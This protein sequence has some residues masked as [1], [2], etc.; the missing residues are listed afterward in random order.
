MVSLFKILKRN[1]FLRAFAKILLAT[2]MVLGILLAALLPVE[3]RTSWLQAHLFSHWR[4][5]LNYSVEKGPSSRVVFPGRGPEDLRRGYAEL[6]AFTAILQ[7][8]G[9]VIEQQAQFSPALMRWTQRGFPPPYSEKLQ[10]GLRIYD[11][12]KTLLYAALDPQRVYPAFDSIPPLVVQTLLFIENQHLL[13]STRLWMNPAVDWPRFCKALGEVTKRKIGLPYSSMGGSTLATQ[14]EKYCHSGEGVTSTG[15]EKIDQM[16]SASMRA[17][18]DGP[19]T[20]EARRQIVLQYVNTVPLAALP[21]YGEVHGLGDGLAA[22]YDTPLDTLNRYLR[23]TV[24]MDRWGYAYRKMLH[25]FIA[26]RRPSDYL[27]SHPDVLFSLGDRYTRLL[28]DQGILSPRMRDAVLAARPPLVWHQG[29]E[30][31]PDFVGQKAINA[32]RNRLARLLGVPRLYNLD[33][34]DLSVSTSVDGGVQAAVVQTLKR[35]GDPRFLDSAGLKSFRL[36]DKGDPAKVI[37]SFTLFETVGQNNL[38]RVQADN[39]EQ[40]LDINDQAKL[41]LGS[42]AKLRTLVHYLEILSELHQRFAGLSSDSLLDTAAQAEDTLTRWTADY[43][44]HATDTS[45]QALLEAGMQRTYSA[46]PGEIFFTGGGQQTFANFDS[47]E[48]PQVYSVHDAFQNSINLS[49]VRL[50]RDEV[51]FHIAQRVSPK[52]IFGADSPARR[53]Y[54]ESFALRDGE[55]FLFRFFEEYRDSS[56]FEGGTAPETFLDNLSRGGSYRLASAYRY[57]YPDSGVPGFES[58]VL[59]TLG[60]SLQSAADLRNIFN[61]IASHSDWTL[62][63]YGFSA[64]VHPL[65]LWLVRYLGAHPNASWSEVTSAARQPILDSYDWIFRISPSL[66][67]EHIHT[68]LETEA[69][70]EIHRAWKRLGYPFGSLVPSLGTAIGSSADRPNALADLMGILLNEGRHYPSSMVQRLHFAAGTPYE[71]VF[72]RSPGS[73]DTLLSPEICRIVREAMVDVVDNGT[74]ARGKDAFRQPDGTLIPLGG[75]TGTGD[76][77]YDT[78]GSK[79]EILNSRVVNRTA[80]FVFFLGDRFFGALT[81]YVQGPQAAN[82]GFTS[83]LPVSVL[84]LLR[85]YLMPLLSHPP[86]PQVVEA[87]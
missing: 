66:Q 27:L 30:I 84:V 48:N 11:R 53:R 73:V 3:I 1:P 60:D 42:T 18:G 35:L 45:L 55:T 81:V 58:F 75:K 50:M 19:R 16:I 5:A 70:S 22:W 76:Q 6:P 43:M 28:C 57:L 2:F 86:A 69:F 54:L 79:G 13:D 62:A 15:E 63:D 33:R 87:L 41:E 20:L 47:T 83:A 14:I 67:N 37:Y 71:T 25:L 24:H 38:L 34:L 74:A 23:D 51:N 77:R 21:G 40:P 82:Y 9:Y 49:F 56:S 72:S 46:D 32:V 10:T 7:Q 64:G 85:P 52:K 78:F 36:M 68:A 59:D 65:E 17:Y 44:A 80:T 31:P 8:R 4:R 39:Y 29:S 61:R 26:H 12:Q